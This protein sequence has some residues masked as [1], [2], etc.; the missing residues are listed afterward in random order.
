[1]HIVGWQ[2]RALYSVVDR[3]GLGF[4]RGLKRSSARHPPPI[5]PAH[6]PAKWD[7]VRG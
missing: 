6:V 4:C 3:H 7:P 5:A 2:Y 1:M